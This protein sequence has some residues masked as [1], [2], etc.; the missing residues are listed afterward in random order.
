MQSRGMTAA[1]LVAIG[2]L[3]S[4]SA[5]AD[6]TMVIAA[7]DKPQIL[8]DKIVVAPGARVTVRNI[9]ASRAVHLPRIDIEAGSVVTIDGGR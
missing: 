8:F 2:L 3:A 9:D 6:R 7:A 5:S 1:A 4:A